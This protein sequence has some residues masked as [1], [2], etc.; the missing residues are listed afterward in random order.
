MTPSIHKTE[1]K[2][3]ACIASF[4]VEE[5]AFTDFGAAAKSLQVYSDLDKILKVEDNEQ[6]NI[7]IEAYKVNKMEDISNGFSELIPCEEYQ[8]E[9]SKLMSELETAFKDLKG[10]QDNKNFLQV[11]KLFANELNIYLTGEPTD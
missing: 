1:Q 7:E 8:S 4:E 3:I 11:H 9:I 6:K 5:R 2:K 10:Q